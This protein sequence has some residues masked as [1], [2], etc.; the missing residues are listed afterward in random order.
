M[1]FEAWLKQHVERCTETGDGEECI[2][3]AWDAALAQRAERETALRALDLAIGDLEDG[4]RWRVRALCLERRA[5][6]RPAEVG[7]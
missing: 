4:W 7:P 5:L 1:E 3:A 6:H 2:R